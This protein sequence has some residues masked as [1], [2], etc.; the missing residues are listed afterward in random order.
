MTRS[1]GFSGLI[2]A[3]SAA[4]LDHGVAHGG[5]VDDGRHAGKGPASA[6]RAG[7]KLISCS[8]EPLLTQP[9]GDRLDV[10]LGDRHAV[11]EA[12]QVFQ[13]DLQRRRQGG[14]ALQAI[15]FGRLEIVVG[16]GF[17]ADRK[18]RSST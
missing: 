1:T 10:V 6:P 18:G 5:Q 11:F 12:Q 4:Q 8:T 7:R 14:D 2:F 16:V 17:V 13:Q 9:V 3:G 15:G